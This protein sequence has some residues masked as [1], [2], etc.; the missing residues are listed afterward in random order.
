MREE[1]IISADHSSLVEETL[2]LLDKYGVLIIEDYIQNE[3]LEQLKSEYEIVLKTEN[4]FTHHLPYPQGIARKIDFKDVVKETFPTVYDVFNASYMKNVADRYLGSPNHFNHEIYVARDEHEEINAL[5]EMHYDKLSTLK[6]F[7]Y[8]NDIDRS[9]GAFEA[10]PGSHKIAQEIMH[11]H[12]RKGRKLVN[13]PNRNLPEGLDNGVAMEAKAGSMIVF[14]T[15]T[16]HRAGRVDAGKNRMIMRGHCRR[17]PM[18]KYSPT[19]LSKQWLQESFLNPAKFYYG[20][21]N[22]IGSEK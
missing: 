5:N 16:Y 8:L 9:N 18:P 11:N 4:E 1:F 7:V 15:D 2:R 12:R 17:K 21:A 10:V 20:F 3:Q 14:T 22:L 6:F 19:I 13:L